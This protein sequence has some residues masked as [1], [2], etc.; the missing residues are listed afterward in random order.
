MSRDVLEGFYN[1][2]KPQ[3]RISGDGA[4]DCAVI[5]A[6]RC[7]PNALLKACILLPVASIVDA[8]R[9]WDPD[10]Q[11]N[12]ADFYYIDARCGRAADDPL[13]AV[14]YLGPNWY[15]RENTQATGY[16]GYAKG[17]DGA[18]RILFKC[19]LCFR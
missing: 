11:D 19:L 16:D 14:P 6:I 3:Q 12:E 5:D 9:E 4:E 8:I 10:K 18:R 1:V 7:R 13:D 2:S 15:P 17:V